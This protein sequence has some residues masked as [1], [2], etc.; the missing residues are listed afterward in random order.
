MSHVG[1]GMRARTTLTLPSVDAARLQKSLNA[2]AP[3]LVTQKH[4]PGPLWAVARFLVVL[5]VLAVAV[6]ALVLGSIAVSR[7]SATSLRTV[8]TPNDMLVVGSTAQR[9]QRHE[10]GCAVSTRISELPIP[11]PASPIGDGLTNLFFDLA[12][13]TPGGLPHVPLGFTFT[14]AGNVQ[15]PPVGALPSPGGG[16]PK[17]QALIGTLYASG[18]AV[19]PSDS[20]IKEN[21]AFYSSSEALAVVN[22]LRP[23]KYNHIEA[24]AA[25]TDASYR[26]QRHGL[27]SEEV[28]LLVPHA[29]RTVAA[30]ELA[31]G[32]V[33]EDFKMLQKG[34]LVVELIGAVQELSRRLS[35]LRDLVE[36]V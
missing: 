36:S 21:S 29:V 4:A 22:A 30:L 17:G 20:R 18:G 26:E 28:E 8:A 13:C 27:F 35:D 23:R 24:F 19:V 11:D 25:L 5:G 12:A 34:D 7:H 2:G 10:A 9:F 33:L 14:C 6:A 32:T 15:P 16:C 1:P 3:L 31:D